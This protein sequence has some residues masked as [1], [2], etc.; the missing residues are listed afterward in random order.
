MPRKESSVKCRYTLLN[1]RGEVAFNRILREEFPTLRFVSEERYFT[2]DIPTYENLWEC[3]N[4]RFEAFVAPEGWQPLI[5]NWNRPFGN[6]Y[7]LHLPRLHFRMNRCK[8][9]WCDPGPKYAFELPY[10]KPGHVEGTFWRENDEEK[11]LFL[12]RVWRLLSKISDCYGERWCGY[13]AL[14]Y[15]LERPRRMLAGSIRPVADW[16]FPE[17]NPYYRDELWDDQPPA[18]PTLEVIGDPWEQTFDR[19]PYYYGPEHYY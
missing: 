16:V 2:D 7:Y 1:D 4:D 15:T 9:V 8:W 5:L 19:E 10:L 11:R 13:D 18:E 17:D 12:V 6:E 3:P 14:R